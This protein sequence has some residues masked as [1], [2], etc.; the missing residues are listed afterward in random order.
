[1]NRVWGCHG[2][3]FGRGMLVAEGW[4]EDWRGDRR[5]RRGQN[6]IW[7]REIGWIGGSSGRIGL[8][9]VVP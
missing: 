2:G 3:G 7:L 5:R 9:T 1:M 4:Y 8:R 6:W